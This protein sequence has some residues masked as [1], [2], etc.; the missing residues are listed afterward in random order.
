MRILITHYH[1]LDFL[2]FTTSLEW[3]FYHFQLAHHGVSSTHYEKYQTL[4]RII[5]QG[6]LFPLLEQ[7]VR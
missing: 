2:R 5:C 7:R 4:R 6:S 1:T 3:P